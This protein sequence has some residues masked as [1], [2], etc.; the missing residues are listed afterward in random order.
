MKRQPLPKSRAFCCPHPKWVVHSAAWTVGPRSWTVA[1]SQADVK[2][3]TPIQG[4]GARRSVPGREVSM[5]LRQARASAQVTA[6]LQ[7]L[8]AR[9]VTAG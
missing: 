1:A 2:P 9:P 8:V 3:V 6:S 7:T 5:I 4:R